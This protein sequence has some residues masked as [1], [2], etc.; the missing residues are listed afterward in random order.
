ME[1]R[2]WSRRVGGG[3]LQLWKQQLVFHFRERSERKVEDEAKKFRVL[4]D[5][6]ERCVFMERDCVWCRRKFERRK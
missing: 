3:A 2:W 1:V 4:E 6:E 5:K